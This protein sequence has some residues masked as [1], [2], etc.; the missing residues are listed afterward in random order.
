[1]DWVTV[2]KIGA[3]LLSAKASS[4]AA[5][6]TATASQTDLKKLRDDAQAAGFNP[7]TVLRATG[8]QGF[9]KGSSGALAS[10]TF[11]GNF[12]NAGQSALNEFDPYNQKR[13]E[14]DIQQAQASLNN[15]MASTQLIKMQLNAPLASGSIPARI[16]QN[17]FYDQLKPP[18]FR[19]TL[20]KDKNV[21]DEEPFALWQTKVDSD[22]TTF[23]MPRGEDPSEILANTVVIAGWRAR[24]K[25][26]EA[27]KAMSS[28]GEGIGSGRYKRAVL[29]NITN[30][31]NRAKTGQI[32]RQNFEL[33]GK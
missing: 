1:M 19:L 31:W 16:G 14:L 25:Y 28:L 33:M 22:G 26:L 23:S 21:V 10:A 13:K 8:G 27:Q 29:E 18:S 5:K 2:A 9:N 15:T 4:D 32:S 7:L 24:Q 11:L 17:D 3:Q 12:A 30:V 20:D 6:A